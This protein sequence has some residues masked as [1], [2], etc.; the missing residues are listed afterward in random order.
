[1]EQER[2]QSASSSTCNRLSCYG[3]A[4]CLVQDS[5][6]ILLPENGEVD[7]EQASEQ[8]EKALQNFKK[9]NHLKGI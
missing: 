6:L 4:L 1:M 7:A 8:L 2:S 5:L 9:V 3:Q